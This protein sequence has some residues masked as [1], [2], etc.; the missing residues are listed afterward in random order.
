MEDKMK[1]KTGLLHTALTVALGIC[2]TATQCAITDVR[3][4]TR[5]NMT[6]CLLADYHLFNP[7]RDLANLQY[8]DPNLQAQPGEPAGIEYYQGAR[9]MRNQQRQRL[10]QLIRYSAQHAST[11]VF[12]E[13]PISALE[14]THPFRKQTH[15][16]CGYV[17]HRAALAR[18]HDPCDDFLPGLFSYLRTASPQAVVRQLDIRVCLAGIIPICG[19]AQSVRFMLEDSINPEQKEAAQYTCIN[20]LER[21]HNENNQR[22]WLCTLNEIIKLLATRTQELALPPDLQAHLLN[23]ID[24]ANRRIRNHA[25]KLFA[26]C[27]TGTFEL[28]TRHGP[29]TRTMTKKLQEI[30]SMLLPLYCDTSDLQDLQTIIEIMAA[31]QSM[32]AGKQSTI[33]CAVGA[34]HAAKL[35]TW[36]QG[37]F[38]F[39]SRQLSPDNPQARP[40][41]DLL[42]PAR[43]LVDHERGIYTL[44]A[45]RH[46]WRQF[47][48]EV[49]CATDE[50]ESD[51]SSALSSDLDDA[52]EEEESATEIE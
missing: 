27:N 50:S 22:I 19:I 44:E 16:L 36:L 52:M 31:Y 48:A 38:E 14:E 25:Q 47:F 40:L 39:Q 42:A 46:N 23:A 1:L 8:I 37:L 34:I 9:I 6:I 32:P 2:A 10:L 11:M 26:A 45:T 21:L 33:Y 12:V 13:D 41:A 17:R 18:S 35:Q 4:L 20:G 51:D 43:A 15:V 49:P 7:V 29:V 28:L 3:I 30:E 24:E 5:G